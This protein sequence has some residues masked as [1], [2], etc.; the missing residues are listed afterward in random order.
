MKTSS[1]PPPPDVDEPVNTAHAVTEWGLDY[2]VL[3]S[4]DR[5]GKEQSADE[6][7]ASKI[8]SQSENSVLRITRSYIILAYLRAVIL[9]AREGFMQ[10]C[11]TAAQLISPK[12]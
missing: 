6:H 3:T 10:I 5:D 4:V 11:Q 1:Q 12:L 8:V 9:Y 7:I 2:V